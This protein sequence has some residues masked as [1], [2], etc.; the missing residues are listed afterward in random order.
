MDCEQSYFYEMFPLSIL[1]LAMYNYSS[2]ISFIIN[3]TGKG[4]ISIS[5]RNIIVDTT[6]GQLSV[7]NVKLPSLDWEVHLFK[8]EHDIKDGLNGLDNVKDIDTIRCNVNGSTLLC[9]FIYPEQLCVE[10]I[11]GYISSIFDDECFV[12]TVKRGE[13][14]DYRKFANEFMLIL[15]DL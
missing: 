8:S 1:G 15:E 10:E 7:P 6:I 3:G 5:K 4:V 12:F 13:M 14:I 11:R 2:L 9:E